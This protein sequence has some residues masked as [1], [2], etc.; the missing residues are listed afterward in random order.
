MIID[1]IPATK[2]M[3]KVPKKRGRPR[4]NALPNTTKP[5][6]TSSFQDLELSKDPLSLDQSSTFM[7]GLQQH[8]PLHHHL[9]HQK[10]SR[11]YHSHDMSDGNDPVRPRRTCRS[12]KSYAPP[13]RGRGRGKLKK[14]FFLC[15]IRIKKKLIKNLRYTNFLCINFI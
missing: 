6:S 8:Q 15:L 3:T 14:I 5:Y 4:R 7:A 1:E 12:Q 13:K 2:L 9:H 11:Q 10:Q